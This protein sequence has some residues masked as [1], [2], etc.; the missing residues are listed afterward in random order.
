MLVYC[1]VILKQLMDIIPNEEF[2]L[3]VFVGLVE[4]RICKEPTIIALQETWIPCIFSQTHLTK[5][6]S[7]CR[8]FSRMDD[9]N[10]CRKAFYLDPFM[11][12]T[13]QNHGKKHGF[14]HI[15]PL[16]AMRPEV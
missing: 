10:I 16:D 14:W 3:H 11:V 2:S 4:R 1:R 5:I 12:R 8:F 15:F 13:R 6:W 9:W 7:S